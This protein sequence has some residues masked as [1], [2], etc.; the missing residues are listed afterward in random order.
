MSSKKADL[1]GKTPQWEP[2]MVTC[3]KTPTAVTWSERLRYI[4]VLFLRKKH[5]Q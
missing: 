1:G 3:G 2:Y 4:T 5:P